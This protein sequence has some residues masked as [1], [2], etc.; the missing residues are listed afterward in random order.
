MYVSAALRFRTSGLALW[1]PAALLFTGFLTLKLFD[2]Q[3]NETMHIISGTLHITPPRW[4]PLIL[5]IIIIIIIIILFAQ[6]AASSS[7]HDDRKQRQSV[8]VFYSQKAVG[9]QSF[10]TTLAH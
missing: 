8:P 4:S 5:V 2:T 6:K 9:C 10:H 1:Y 3:L 7:Y